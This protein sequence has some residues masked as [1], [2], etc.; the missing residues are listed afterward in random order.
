ME[1]EKIAIQFLRGKDGLLGFS[2]AGMITE[3]N[4]TEQKY[5]CGNWNEGTMP[6]CSANLTMHGLTEPHAVDR[7][8][9]DFK[10]Q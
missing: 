2:I 4:G 8:S 7:E 10:N 6:E 1:E 3:V 5:Q 9:T